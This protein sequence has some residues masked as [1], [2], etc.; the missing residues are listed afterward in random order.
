MWATGRNSKMSNR[1]ETLTHDTVNELLAHVLAADDALAS[2]EW[3]SE[4][5]VFER[6][7]LCVHVLGRRAEALGLDRLARL[8]SDVSVTLSA[9]LHTR[10]PVCADTLDHIERGLI[11]LGVMVRDLERQLDGH[12][13]AALDDAIDALM[14]MRRDYL[15]RDRTA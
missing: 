4:T 3:V 15:R 7:W 8:S 5:D 14:D 13:P 9:L 2:P 12:A 1:K 6:V 11:V 10:T